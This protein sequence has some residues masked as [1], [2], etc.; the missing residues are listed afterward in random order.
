M[1]K[2]LLHRS[3]LR[4]KN[5]SFWDHTT[6]ELELTPIESQQ[7]LWTNLGSVQRAFQLPTDLIMRHGLSS[8]YCIKGPNYDHDSLYDT[9]KKIQRDSMH[10]EGE[11]FIVVPD[12][13]C[14][15]A[16]RDLIIA[17]LA[18][19]VDLQCDTEP[20]NVVFPVFVL[21]PAGYTIAHNAFRLLDVTNPCIGTVGFKQLFAVFDF[22]THQITAFTTQGPS[23]LK[24]RTSQSEEEEQQPHTEYQQDQTIFQEETHHFRRP[25][26]VLGAG[27]GLGLGSCLRRHK[28]RAHHPRMQHDKTPNPRKK[29]KGQSP[30]N[31]LNMYLD[32]EQCEMICQLEMET[33]D[34]INDNNDEQYYTIHKEHTISQLR[35]QNEMEDKERANKE[36]ERIEKE[37]EK[38]ERTNEE[39]TRIQKE[40]ED[41]ERIRKEM[42]D[43]ERIQKEVEDKERIQ[44]EI[45]DNERIQK[46]IEDKERIQKEIEDK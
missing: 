26:L 11:L 45:E 19:Y 14:Q 21:E 13:V 36:T 43:K 34:R 1:H 42:E 25:G 37:A 24:T 30:Q 12:C 18:V 3:T 29:P 9:I 32:P 33:R 39:T 2:F 40:M 7:F 10:M 31:T 17:S 8:L 5:R 27:L 35:I 15:A 6:E 22:H 4:Y 38:K 41:K 23:N 16:M 20:K 46:E 44:K 28:T